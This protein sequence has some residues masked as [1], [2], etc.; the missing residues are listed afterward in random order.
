MDCYM[1]QS[2]EPELRPQCGKQTVILGPVVI[3]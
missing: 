2:I 1:E 3:V